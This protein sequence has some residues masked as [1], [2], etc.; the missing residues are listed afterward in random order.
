MHAKKINHIPNIEESFGQILA[1]TIDASSVA[2]AMEMMTGYVM[3][4]Y[5][6]CYLADSKDTRHRLMY[7]GR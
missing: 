7:L 2:V 1:T 4:S 3:S 6:V 5:C